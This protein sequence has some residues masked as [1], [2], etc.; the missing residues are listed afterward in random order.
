MNSIEHRLKKLMGELS[1]RKF[2]E[3]LGVPTTTLQ[4]YL[5]GRM[6]PADFVVLVCERCV[7]DSWWLLTGEQPSEMSLETKPK[8]GELEGMLHRILK[9]GDS[10]KEAAVRAVLTVLDPGED[11]LAVVKKKRA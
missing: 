6:P 3:K 10:T 7:V 8:S 1:V 4:Q 11:T 5:K 9:E 2:A